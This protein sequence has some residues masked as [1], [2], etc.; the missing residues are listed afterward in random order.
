VL[1]VGLFLIIVVVAVAVYC[2]R[3]VGTGRRGRYE[4]ALECK[5]MGIDNL[6]YDMIDTVNDDND[7]NVDG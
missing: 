6:N 7:N 3:S 2:W 4:V 1:G 5:E